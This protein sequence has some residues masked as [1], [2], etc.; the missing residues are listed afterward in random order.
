[1]K[2]LISTLIICLLFSLSSVAQ[3]KGFIYQTGSVILD[4]NS[5]GYTSETTSGFAGD[6][7]DVDEF[8]ITMFPLPTLGT[9]EALGD[10]SSGPNCGFTDLAV[11]TNGNA[12]YFAFDS[13]NLIIRFRLGGYAPNAKGY[14]VLIDTDGKFGSQDTNST[15]ENPGFEVAIVLRSKSDVFIADIDG[16]DD[17]SD[18]KETYSLS[19]H[20]QKS[21]AGI[22][23]CNDPDYFYDFYAPLSDLTTYFGITASS[24][25]RMVSITNPERIDGKG[26][27]ETQLVNDCG[28]EGSVVSDCSE[29]QHQENR[30][31]E[32][33]ITK[34]K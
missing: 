12:T 18:V 19:S 20:H 6:G 23:S 17:C 26:Y 16:A 2:S 27:G 25:L 32:F 1:M 30:R 28:C 4:P 11:D 29:D 33:K 34:A 7:H 31:T 10:I 22:E 13:S 15:D 21:I 24:S 5:D 8:E 9:G 14:S 3:T